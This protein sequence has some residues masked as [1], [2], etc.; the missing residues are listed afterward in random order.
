MSELERFRAET[1][2][3]LEAHCPPEVR[4]PVTSE[5]EVIWGGRKAVFASP[6]HALWLKLMGER[7][8]TAPE[9]PVEYGGG[10]LSRDEAKVLA[11]ELARIGA[12][13]ALNSF[14][15]WMLGP[16]LLK[17]GTEAQKRRFLPEIVR[18]EIRWCQGYSEPG[19]GS[20]L[21]GLQTRA[22][23]QGDHWIV[24]GQKVWTSYADKADWI[25]CLVRTD[26]EAPKHLGISFVL[27]D[28]ATPGVTTKPITLIS[29]KSPFCETFFDDVRVEKENL[30]GELNRGWD[31]AKHLLAHERTM[32][33]AMGEIGGG[34]PLGQV[35]TGS[36]G[37]DDDGRLLDP[38]LR[39]RIAE[40]EVDAAAFRLALERTGDRMKARQAH[41]ALASMLKYYGSELNK[42]RHELLMAAGGSDAL[43]WEGERSRDGA[44]A[45]DWLRTK[46]NSIEGGTSEIQ[47]N[48]LAKHV[49]QL[50][51]A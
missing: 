14:G 43:E 28:M 39:A 32:I 48:I 45:R 35:A 47:L 37:T 51:G 34:R 41:P 24:N 9:W 7:G 33:G 22:V 40:L 4:G 23:D 30:V 25:F 16:A 20:D 1:R 11:Q 29:G 50:P 13:P 3:W 42:R 5:D 10:G 27:F 17:F 46:A 38:M 26:P 12:Q 49:L 8:W 21:A 15:V 19:A 6:G 36:I 18:G 44:V 2:A 31:V